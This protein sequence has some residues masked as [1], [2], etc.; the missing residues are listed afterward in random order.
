MIS[1]AGMGSIISAR[2]V[3]IP[4]IIFPRLAA[5]GEH[6][7]DHQLDTVK[8]FANRPGIYATSDYETL[9]AAVTVAFTDPRRVGEHA[10]SGGTNDLLD[11]LAVCIGKMLRS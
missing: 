7:N 3:Q 10:S 6:R 8:Q 2:D 4:I 5:M 1:H 11:Y 9:E